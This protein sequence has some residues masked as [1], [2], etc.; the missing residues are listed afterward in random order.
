MATRRKRDNE[1]LP[2]GQQISGWI[3]RDSI[4]S[5]PGKVFHGPRRVPMDELSPPRLTGLPQRHTRPVN[6]PKSA[7][8]IGFS[9]DFTFSTGHVSGFQSSSRADC[10]ISLKLSAPGQPEIK[11]EKKL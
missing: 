10:I 2:G 3:S 9:S 6:T 8:G 7:A 11:G 1:F 5:W 4:E